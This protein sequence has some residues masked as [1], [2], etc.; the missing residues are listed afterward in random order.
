MLVVSVMVVVLLSYFKKKEL[1]DL[2]D[3]VIIFQGIG[4]TLGLIH[5]NYLKIQI[6][7]STPDYNLDFNSMIY[8][9]FIY[10]IFNFYFIVHIHS[11]KKKTILILSFWGIMLLYF[12]DFG[13]VN[14]WML[15]VLILF[16]GGS[17][18]KGFKTNENLLTEYLKKLQL[19][20]NEEKN[21]KHLIDHMQ[22]GFILIKENWDIFY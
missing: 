14:F 18:C 19:K 22:Q 5:H 16:L 17:I 4:Q 10:I 12:H 13:D 15:N 8:N 11:W 21:W 1:Y 3:I 9:M 6:I 2:F 7:K 20:F